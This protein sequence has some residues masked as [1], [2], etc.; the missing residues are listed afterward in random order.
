MVTS[1]NV[2]VSGAF[3]RELRVALAVSAVV[4]DG[5]LLAH[6]PE[7]LPL[8]S[9]KVTELWLIPPPLALCVTELGIH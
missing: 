6:P 3:R 1:L 7:P 8:S 2:S 4:V 9:I 5:V